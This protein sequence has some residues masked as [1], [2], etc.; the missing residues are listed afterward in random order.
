[1][2]FFANPLIVF[3]DDALEYLRGIQGQRALIVT[4]R[5]M[6][7]LGFAKRVGRELARAG[8]EY[9]VY[10]EVEPD[11]SLQTIKR[12]AQVALDYQPDWLI[13]LGGG[14]SM[15]AAKGI[16]VL[17]ARPDIEPDAI[18]P[19]EVLNLR[20]KAHLIA[21]PTTSGTG[22][23]VTWMIVVTDVE[24]Q[25]KIG[26]GSRETMP[27]VAILDPFFVMNLPPQITGDTGMDA[28][29]HAIEGYTSNWRSD[30]TDGPA[31]I[32]IKRIFEC[33]PRVYEDGSD[34]EART[35][36]MHAATLASMSFG[37]AMAGLGHS[38]GHALG[39]LFHVPHGRAVGLFLPYTMEYL[40]EAAAPLYADIAHFI[41][42]GDG[43]DLEVTR[44]LTARV[45]ALAKRVGQPLSVR[46]AGIEQAAYEKALSALVERA[47]NEA[48]TITVARIPDSADLER[49][50]R[51][52]Y[53]GM[54]VDF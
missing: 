1:M 53:Q 34:V 37:N 50:F 52:A 46:E 20:Q 30:F 18:N 27:D 41:G 24:G 14:S 38:M 25:R 35:H 26:V 2:W 12:G 16:W 5:K 54:T 9:R 43:S 19:S 28:L 40:A 6:V 23:E 45:R 8:L 29:C 31:L 36:M 48:T 7:E 42:I 39:G 22:A 21:I 11:P 15:D 47:E 44:E 49:L 32:A 13:G 4:D 33:L 3:G 10:D 17:Y 51:Y